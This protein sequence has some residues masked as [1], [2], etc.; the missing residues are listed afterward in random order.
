MSCARRSMR[1]SAFPTSSPERCSARTATKYG[2]Y[3]AYINS[4]GGH[5]LSIINEILD[6]AK[7]ESGKL[8]LQEEEVDLLSCIEE[9]MR[10]C[11]HGAETGGVGLGLARQQD[12]AVALADRRLCSRSVSI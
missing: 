6:L 4:S 11:R 3:S 7:A 2:E 1:S 12:E 8:S 9:C 10:T 5:L